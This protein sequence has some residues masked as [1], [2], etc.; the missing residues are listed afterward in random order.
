MRISIAERRI[1]IAGLKYPESVGL[2][3]APEKIQIGKIW[4]TLNSS[5]LG[6]KI[7]RQKALKRAKFLRN[8]GW[9]ARVFR[10]KLRNN[11]S[12]NLIYTA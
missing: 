9:K 8:H 1:H 7:G 2:P 5:F 3:W 6:T 12:Y 10:R 11:E 4:Y